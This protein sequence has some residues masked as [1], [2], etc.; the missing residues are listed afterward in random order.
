MKQFFFQYIPYYKNYKMRFF[1]VF[2]GMLLVAGG[3]SGSAYAVKPLL[4]KIFIN[5]DQQ[6]LSVLP[7]IVVLLY[8]AKGFG[9]YIQAYNIAYIGEDIIRIIRDKMFA[10]ILTFDLAFFHNKHSGDLISRITNDINRIQLAV[11]NQ[12]AD[13]FREILTAFA[14]VFVVIYQSPTLAFYS[15][16]VLPLAVYPLSILAK[17]MRKLSFRSQESTAD[18][19]S[20]LTEAFNNIEIIKAN[21]TEEYESKKFEKRNKKLFDIN[22]KSVKTNELTNPL[23]ETLGAFAFAVVIFIGGN[24]VIK[25]YLTIGEFFSFL[26]ALFMLYTPIRK[27]SSIYNSMQNALAANERVNEILNMKASV[28]GGK[29][30]FPKDLQKI[31]FQN[32]ELKYDTAVA[33]KNINLEVNIG[34]KIALVGNSGG[35]K[36]SLV[37]LIVRFYDPTKGKIL[38]NGIDSQEID[39]QALRDNISIVTQRVYIFN[40]TIAANVAYGFEIDEEKVIMALKQSNAYDFVLNLPNGIY[41]TLEQS[42]SN[43][44]G[45]QRQRIAIAR[46]LYKSPKI[47]ILDE[48]TSALDNTSESIITE[49]IDGISHDKITFVIAH[50]LSTIKNIDKIAVFKD[51]EIVAIDTEENLLAS[52]D[53]FKKLKNLS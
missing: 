52:C 18:I 22:L 35:G 6:M 47:L 29:K 8:F 36:S 38:Y 32:V 31:S 2:I 20:N 30:S 19:L 45:G 41:T 15:L 11:S 16:I 49:I 42:G 39:I 53:E 37:N 28:V 3:T 46:A 24:E 26:T 7:A 25:G 48:A 4:D 50:R 21:S 12:V 27:I 40:D 5:K 34:E 1:L 14:L 10:H 13:F 17:K 44:S 33:L 51:G 23:M 9:A 43:L